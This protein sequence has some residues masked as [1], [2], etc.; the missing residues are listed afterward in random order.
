MVKKSR[1]KN[2]DI[3]MNIKKLKEKIEFNSLYYRQEIILVSVGFIVGLII[4]V[5]I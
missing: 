1:S 4:G 5:I 3:K 2:R